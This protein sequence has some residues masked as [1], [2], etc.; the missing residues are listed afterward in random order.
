MLTILLTRHGHT[1]RSEPEQYLGQSVPASLTERG[2]RDA[3][4][5]AD[6]LADVPIDR[7]VSSPLSRAI[8]TA[9]IVVS[10]RPLE[11]EPDERFT[12]LDYGVWEGMFLDDILIQFPGEFDLYDANPSTHHV[13]GGENGSEV[14][15]R[16]RPLMSELL[17]WA[18]GADG[19]RTCLL[20]GHSSV[21][22]VFLAEVMGVPLID[23]RR[24]F[25]QDWVNLTV[26][27]WESRES[28]PLMLL[29]NDLAHVRGVRGIT[30]D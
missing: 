26:L 28:G 4:A 9:Q 19:N 7:V 2:T 22:R 8:E 6:R 23:Y 3:R 29:A 18:E 17:D 20:V 14:A 21:N 25:Q 27:H 12:E 11:I 15:D 16:V 30:W 13:G 1:T 10:G 5:L 24:R